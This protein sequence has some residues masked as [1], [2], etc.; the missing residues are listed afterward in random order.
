MSVRFLSVA[1]VAG[2]LMAATVAACE[3]YEPPTPGAP[4]LRIPSSKPPRCLTLAECDAKWLA[5][6]RRS[7]GGIGPEQEQ[8]A[9]DLH[10]LGSTAWPLIARRALDSDEAISQI[11]RYTMKDWPELTPA[12]FGDLAAVLIRRPGGWPAWAMARLGTPAAI[13]FLLADLARTQTGSQSLAIGLT[14][15]GSLPQVLKV[16]AAPVNANQSEGIHKVFAF[17]SADDERTTTIAAALVDAAHEDVRQGTPALTLL[18]GI[19]RGARVDTAAVRPLLTSSERKVR[20]LA[21]AVLIRF[22]DETGLA[23]L[24]AKCRDVLQ[25]ESAPDGPAPV[26]LEVYL[27]SFECL[28][29]LARMGVRAARAAPWLVERSAVVHAQIR[30]AVLATLGYVGDASVAGALRARLESDDDRDVT[31][32][33]ESLWRLRSRESLP[34]IHKVATSHWYLPVR[35]VAR[36]VETAIA[37]GQHEPVET[38]LV[39]SR[40]GDR[41]VDL[42]TEGGVLW[43]V[44]GLNECAAW[45]TGSGEQLDATFVRSGAEWRFARL[46]DGRLAGW[47]KGEFGGGLWY[48]P[49]AGAEQK[50]LKDRVAEIADMSGGKAIVFSY[51]EWESGRVAI[52]ELSQRTARVTRMRRLPSPPRHVRRSGGGWFV[53]LESRRGVQV[54][55]DLSF[56]EVPCSLRLPGR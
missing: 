24:L 43:R 41:R 25:P 10:A 37:T 46:G 3:P 47:N 34:A 5:L 17:L 6:A 40:R 13:E 22:G 2:A 52:V 38:L 14:L 4:Q 12:H 36:L 48:R 56:T 28:E 33:L 7:T 23:P 44:A 50:L 16:F 42:H 26:A 27:E 35:M 39:D 20:A 31:A 54:G 9:R 30:S 11:A 15:P 45:T 55:T 1:A 18:L 29:P 51:D 21:E 19:N 53:E 32:S 49:T 8:L